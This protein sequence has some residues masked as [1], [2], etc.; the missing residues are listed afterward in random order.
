MFASR[1]SPEYTRVRRSFVMLTT[2]SLCDPSPK[3]TWIRSFEID[4]SN[5][6]RGYD[7]LVVESS[8]WMFQHLLASCPCVYGALMSW[9]PLASGQVGSGLY[10]QQVHLILSKTNNQQPAGSSTGNSWIKGHLGRSRRSNPSLLCIRLNDIVLYTQTHT[11]IHMHAQS[12][13]G[14][15]RLLMMQTNSVG[16]LSRKT[17]LTEKLGSRKNLAPLKRAFLADFKWG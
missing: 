6:G 2:T 5:R 10:D 3:L 12:I 7:R 9:G 13:C 14:C 15:R 4:M 1:R 8:I 16:P 17:W 11:H